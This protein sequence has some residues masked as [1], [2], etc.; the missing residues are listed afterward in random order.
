MEHEKWVD[1]M[2]RDLDG[3]LTQV[4]K[5][6]L[7]KHLA[8][9]SED[10]QTYEEFRSLSDEL[11]RLPK[12][13]PPASLVDSLLSEWEQKPAEHQPETAPPRPTRFARWRPSHKVIAGMATL[14]VVGFASGMW[15]NGLMT[16]PNQSMSSKGSKQ[17]EII[18]PNQMP[19]GE[20]ASLG[21]ES[22]TKVLFSPDQKYQATWQDNHHLI[23]QTKEG[24]IRFNEELP[25]AEQAPN[26]KWVSSQRIMV[27]YK[28]KNG[29]VKKLTIDAVQGKK[30]N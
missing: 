4:E 26:M 6:M 13:M 11:S 23:V 18:D 5:E 22:Q 28:D 25:D 2:Q 20:L 30:V 8:R 1:W 29:H 15:V 7:E 16:D 17:I 27:T 10:A 21:T 24:D 19:P 14:F 12:V 3:D 9:S